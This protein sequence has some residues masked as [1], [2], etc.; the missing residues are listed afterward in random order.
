MRKSASRWL[1]LLAGLFL[2]AGVN[3]CVERRMVIITEPYPDAVN[4]IVYDEKDQPIGGSP[5]DKPFTYYGKYRFRI[6]KD[7]FDTLD[8]EQ[9]VRAPWYELPGLD[10]ISENLI[11]W[12]IRDVR[13]FT[14][15]LQPMP[16]RPPD[17]TL[18]EGETLRIYGKGIGVQTPELNGP[19]PPPPLLK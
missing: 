17:Q 16:I 15:V 18:R 13:Y 12:T 19:I 14:Y 7:G 2:L 9:R 11:P 6:V 3:G 4:A 5:V 10:F 1:T 8:V